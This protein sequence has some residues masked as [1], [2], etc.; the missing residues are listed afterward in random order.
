MDVRKGTEKE[1]HTLRSHPSKE[2]MSK[3][4]RYI[5]GERVEDVNESVTMSVMKTY[6]HKKKWMKKLNS[7]G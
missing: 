7:V 2:W 4:Y 1:Q 5:S 3:A 6:K